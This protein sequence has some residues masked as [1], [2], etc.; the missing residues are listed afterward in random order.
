M[1]SY[2]YIGSACCYCSLVQALPSIGE[3]H[4]KN[5]P[6]VKPHRKERDYQQQLSKI[7]AVIHD[8]NTEQY[9]CQ[10]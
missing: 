4:S 9:R 10:H 8:A 2:R 1:I 3:R 7:T 5:V 6:T